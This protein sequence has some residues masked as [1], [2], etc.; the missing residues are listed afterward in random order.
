MG[1]QRGRKERGRWRKRGEGWGEEESKRRKEREEL[2]EG[3]KECA[4]ISDKFVLRDCI[5]SLSEY[6]VLNV[7]K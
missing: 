6:E 5:A 7:K 1:E 2:R 3:H 4:L